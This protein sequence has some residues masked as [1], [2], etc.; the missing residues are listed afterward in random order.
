MGEAVTTAH[1]NRVI[2]DPSRVLDAVKAEALRR[3]YRVVELGSSWHGDV[4]D[5]VAM[6]SDVVTSND[7]DGPLCVVGVGEVTLRVRGSGTGGRCQ[8]FAWRM[9]K[10][11]DGSERDVV[12][13]ARA[14]DAAGSADSAAAID[15]ISAP[16]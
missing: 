2:A 14:T 5:L 8:E 12:V 6:M 4:S 3:G 1:E 7:E 16:K 13:A 9:A 11:F 15:T 10:V